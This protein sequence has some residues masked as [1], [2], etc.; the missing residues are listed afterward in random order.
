MTVLGRAERAYEFFQENPWGQGANI[1][2]LNGGGF[3]YCL[4]GGVIFCDADPARPYLVPDMP[5]DSVGYLD[6]LDELRKTIRAHG[7]TYIHEYNDKPG[8]TKEEINQIWLE[9]LERLRG[10]E[11][12][13]GCGL[14][15][16]GT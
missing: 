15:V 10:E 2:V 14:I 12:E 8:R 13:N 3:G 16:A 4:Q 11:T 9:T 1:I 6:V 5:H 7:A